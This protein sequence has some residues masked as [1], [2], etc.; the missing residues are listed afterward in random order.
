MIIWKKEIDDQ[1]TPITEGS[2]R[3]IVTKVGS[4]YLVNS[5]MPTQGNPDE[6]GQMT[7]EIYEIIEKYRSK[8]SIIWL[9]DMN[10]SFYREKPSSNDI[11]FKAFAMKCP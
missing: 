11:K 10:A 1:V 6:Y 3:V 5:Y 8:G 7:D 2:S 9:G 4:V